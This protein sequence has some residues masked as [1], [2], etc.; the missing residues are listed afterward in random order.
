MIDTFVENFLVAAAT[1]FTKAAHMLGVVIGLLSIAYIVF[2]IALE[3]PLL[4]VLSIYAAYV[5]LRFISDF[6]Y[7]QFLSLRRALNNF[8]NKRVDL[9]ID[10]VTG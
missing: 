7:L 1:A 9:F 2:P 5:L 8:L 3:L 6:G 10:T 4:D